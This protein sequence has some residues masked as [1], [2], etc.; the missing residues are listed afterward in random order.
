MTGIRHDAADA[1]RI[2]VEEEKPPRARPPSPPGVVANGSTETGLSRTACCG[3]TPVRAGKV[4]G[5]Q[6]HSSSL[7]TA[8]PL[9]VGRRK[10]KRPGK[11][12]SR[13]KMK[14]CNSSI[15][16]SYFSPALPPFKSEAIP[17]D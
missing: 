17:F 1:H 14:C 16:R 9:P 11:T 4:A 13:F 12:P 6:E 10:R 7:L 3:R 15:Q 2:Q 5:A 8:F